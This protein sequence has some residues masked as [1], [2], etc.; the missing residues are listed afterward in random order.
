MLSH[1]ECRRILA[2]HDEIIVPLFDAEAAAVRAC[3]SM[4]MADPD[5]TSA[6]YEEGRAIRREY[7]RMYA[8]MIA[9]GV[10]RYALQLFCSCWTDGE[11]WIP[12]N[13]LLG[14][15]T[16]GAPQ[17]LRNFMADPEWAPC[18]TVVLRD[19]DYDPDRMS[20]CDSA[21]SSATYDGLDELYESNVAL[22]AARFYVYGRNLCFEQ[23]E[24][25]ARD[26]ALRPELMGVEL[27]V[28]RR[29]CP[30]APL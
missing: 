11:D 15:P 4:S 22:S 25:R 6:L 17:V 1:A 20:D 2:D 19:R 12:D 14:V 5:E 18:G 9:S 27:R 16:A 30:R 3:G 21:S 24:D 29:T 7:E 10:P 23:H 26:A 8:A 13:V 28:F